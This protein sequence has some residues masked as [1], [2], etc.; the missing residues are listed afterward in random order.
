MAATVVGPAVTVDW[1]VVTAPAVT[2]KALLLPAVR[3]SPL[4]RVAVRITPLWALVSVSP[5]NVRELVPLL[6]VPVRVPPN[7]PVPVFRLSVTA[8]STVTFWAVPPSP[9]DCTTTLNGVPAV[10]EKPPLTEVMAR[11]VASEP[12][13]TISPV[14][15]RMAPAR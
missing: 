8:V 2:V 13:G 5:V 12:D 15:S 10:G 6:I 4:V 14:P 3:L 11:L 7:G 9:C 1:A